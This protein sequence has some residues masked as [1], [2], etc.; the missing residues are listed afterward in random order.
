MTA[1][2]SLKKEPD[3]IP[4]P[5]ADSLWTNL[6]ARVRGL[7]RLIAAAADESRRRKPRST[8]SQLKLLDKEL[9][10]MRGDIKGLK[11]SPVFM[12]WLKQQTAKTER[13]RRRGY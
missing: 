6:R 5:Y 12:R 11:P 3:F 1:R 2:Q 10:A 7:E 9:R 4:R 8:A 13:R